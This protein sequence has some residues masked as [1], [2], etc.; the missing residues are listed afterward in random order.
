MIHDDPFL[1]LEE[2]DSPEALAWVREQNAR[3]LAL[4]ES[5][6]RYPA[7]LA[8]ARA[9]IAA[10]DR[11]PYPHF[12]GDRLANFWQDEAHV[13]GLWRRTTLD[14]FRT[15]EPRWETLLDIDALAAAEQRNW[16]FQ[17]AV[18]LPPEYRR[19]LVALSDGGKDAKELREFDLAAAR[20]LKN[21]FYLSEAKQSAVWLDEDT[22]L[23]ARDWGPGTLTRRV[24]VH[25]EKLTRGAPLDAAEQ[26]SRHPRCQRARR[27]AR[28]DGAMR[29]P[30]FAPQFLRASLPADDQAPP[31]PVPLRS[32]SAPSSRPAAFR[33]RR[34]GARIFRPAPCIA[35]SRRLQDP[36]VTPIADLCAGA[37]RVDRGH[38]TRSR[39]LVTSTTTSGTAA[40]IVSR[41]ALALAPAIAEERLGALTL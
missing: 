18:S 5:D 20:F 41:T 35:R 19:C 22:L 28:P 40:S 11:I 36:S 1:W 6:P 14:S 29:D 33:W 39:L 26:S 10:P 3:S 7:L 9:V 31:L 4:L 27:F 23:V 2:V 37:A 24:T 21:G 12:L 15:A 17:G 13:R 16:V 34:I 25:P 38:G 32:S 8:E 30:V